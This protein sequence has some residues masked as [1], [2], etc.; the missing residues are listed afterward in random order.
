MSYRANWAKRRS[1]PRMKVAMAKQGSRKSSNELE[2]QGEVLSWLNGEIK[3]RQMGLD[4]AT[5]EKPRASSGKRNDLVVWADRSVESAFLTIELKTPDTPINDPIF[6]ADAI[7][8]AQHWEAPYVAI[9]NMSQFEVYQ[10]P[11]AGGLLLPTDALRRGSLAEPTRSVEDWLVP[12]V[13]KAL[14][15]QST[16][17]L[18]V[19]FEHSISGGSQR[20]AIDAEL[21]VGR[22]TQ[23]ITALRKQLYIDISTA[24]KRDRRLRKLLSAIATE[25]GFIDFVE[26]VDE[27]I[28]GQIS[29]RYVGQILFY[30]ALRRKIPTLPALSLAVDDRFPAAL[31]PYWNE[32]RRYDYEAL[33]GPHAVD[34][35]VQMG[36]RGRFII[37]QLVAQFSEYD[38]SSLNDDVLGSIFE[39]LIPRAEQV[40]LGQFY[41]PQP[42]ADLL[43]AFTVD[44][45]SPVV[46]DPGC[47][48]G[49][50]LMRSYNYLAETRGLSH[51][52]LLS[53]IWG[54]DIS[55]FAAE[56]AVINLYR[57]DMSAFE[58]FPRVV[59][60][61]FIDRSPGELV[62]FPAPRRA[63][64]APEKVAV[65]IPKFDAVLANPPYVRSQHQDDLDPAYRSKLFLS[66]N[67]AGFDAA[68]KTDLFAFFIYH[69]LQFL[70]PGARI[71]FVTSS[72]W[73][74]ADFAGEL[75]KALL[76]RVR[77]IAIITSDAESFFTQVDINTVLII[78]ESLGG[79]STADVRVPFVALRK[80]IT[81]L[82]SGSGAYWDRVHR[83]VD[84][85]ESVSE[86]SEN[87]RYRVR[88][89]SAKEEL[90]AIVDRRRTRNWS[91]YLR[92]PVSYYEIFGDA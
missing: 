58:N 49:T 66:A 68:A 10:T 42:V 29:Y 6:L 79:G 65:P 85:L 90:A 9:W 22:L 13:G 61:S 20:I 8:K 59:T 44:G 39:K 26:N 24:A 63:T 28:A 12:G 2:F 69:T 67:K 80:P 36:P 15:S 64:G 7:E 4:K 3:S 1:Q 72:S 71:G 38:W 91:K 52:A 82:V 51:S 41:T 37:R 18:D 60:G 77:L 88:M 54:F 40:L 89:V 43:V 34:D 27:A 86:T 46:L 11:P 16:E 78:A 5:Q 53:Q 31:T 23:A 73:L 70:K 25:Q 32:V 50:F 47:G 19:A 45:E 17:I 62:Q 76:S 92:A 33:F 30:H 74:T 56:L 35:L 83:L 84:E 14:R 57:Q 48:S 75:Q 55:A 87:D 81:E 21:F